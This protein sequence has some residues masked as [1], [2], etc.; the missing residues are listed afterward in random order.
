MRRALAERLEVPAA[1]VWLLLC[2]VRSDGLIDYWFLVGGTFYRCWAE[3]E[4]EDATMSD[5]VMVA[6]R[7]VGVLSL[8]FAYPE[9]R[10]VYCGFVEE[11][12]GKRAYYFKMGNIVVAVGFPLSNV[13]ER[14]S[15]LP[16]TLQY[17]GN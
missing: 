5:D 7:L 13:F 3:F 14:G 16:R 4:Y 2:A 9:A 17:P 6:S 15:E 8:Q 1:E 12:G 11:I 10:T